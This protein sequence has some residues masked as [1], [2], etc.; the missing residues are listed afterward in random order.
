MRQIH[1]GIFLIPT[2]TPTNMGD[3]NCY[4]VKSGGRSALVDVGCGTDEAHAALEAALDEAGISLDSLE[5]WTTHAHSDH[6]GG[7]ERVWREGMTVRSGMTTYQE[8]RNRNRRRR[9]LFCPQLRRFR[10]VVPEVLPSIEAE[11]NQARF[12]PSLDGPVAHL[13]DGD[14]LAVGDYRFQ[15]VATPGHDVSEVCFWEPD[16]GVL[17]SGD[18][19]LGQVIPSVYVEGFD[20]DEAG[21]FLASLDKVADLPAR[22]V[23]PGHGEPF[24]NLRERCELTKAMLLRRIEDAYDLVASGVEEYMDICHAITHLP[25]RKPWELRNEVGQ[26]KVVTETAGFLANLRSTGRVTMEEEGGV[27]RFFVA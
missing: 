23:A 21:M 25:S 10:Q 1:D 6:I 14:S 20:L 27:Y 5:I 12:S 16:A 24:S 4:L 8:Q 22:I 3:L 7:L 13:S 18:H 26:W 9:E 11:K 19:V 2:P 17:L 15:V